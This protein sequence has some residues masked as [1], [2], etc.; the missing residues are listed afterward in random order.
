MPVVTLLLMGELYDPETKQCFGVKGVG[1]D[2]VADMIVA[3]RPGSKKFAL[4]NALKR[5]VEYR[6]G[7]PQAIYDFPDRKEQPLPDALGFPV[8]TTYRKV[9]ELVGTEI[10]R[11]QLNWPNAWIDALDR[12]VFDVVHELMDDPDLE[13]GLRSLSY[14]VRPA[15][16]IYNLITDVRYVNEY[17]HFKHG[18][19]PGKVKA[20]LVRRPVPLDAPGGS[21]QAA[22]HASNQRY[23]S[24]IPDYTIENDT[25]E[26]GLKLK[27][28]QLLEMVEND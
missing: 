13:K 5:L 12:Q 2:T 15:P 16:I 19:G 8:G 21:Q 26:D 6:L 18:G 27:V 11:D 3:V 7:L 23:S 4:A 10:V 25:T 24:M 22:C 14:P 1:K 17:Q 28:N 9:L 20:V